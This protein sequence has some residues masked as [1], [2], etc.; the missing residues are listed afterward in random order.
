MM[1]VKQIKRIALILL[2]C[3]L[4]FSIG[5]IVSLF[6]VKNIILKILC[7]IVG[8]LMGSALIRIEQKL[9]KQV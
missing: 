9:R 6:V 2:V 7:F 1:S 8:N 4:M 5:S 3:S